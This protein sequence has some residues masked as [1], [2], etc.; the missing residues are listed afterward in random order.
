MGNHPVKAAYSGRN[1]IMPRAVWTGAEAIETSGETVGGVDVDNA[2]KTLPQNFNAGLMVGSE[3]RE[4][5][6]RESKKAFMPLAGASGKLRALEPEKAQ[7]SSE[8][9]MGKSVDELLHSAREQSLMNRLTQII[10]KEIRESKAFGIAKPENEQKGEANEKTFVL[11]KD[12]IPEGAE[13]KSAGKQDAK[14]Q[15]LDSNIKKFEGM[16]INAQKNSAQEIS[17][18]GTSNSP[19]TIENLDEISGKIEFGMDRV[20]ENGESVIRVRLRPEELGRIEIRLVQENGIVKGS[21]LV[22]N[23]GVKEQMCNL[24]LEDK[25][26][27]ALD[28]IKP[29]EIEVGVFNQQTGT[30]KDFGQG[31]SDFQKESRSG[32][33]SDDSKETRDNVWQGS[34][35]G[36]DIQKGLDLFA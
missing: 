19:R 8:G 10:P 12:I 24:L 25:F 22:E 3:S 17:G 6:L 29:K 21:I 5:D 14:R 9:A 20:R 35:E 28:G 13:A 34:E 18:T 32:G 16:P 26:L 2:K 11:V 23:E 4:M 15:L 30:F 27:Q 33:F 36:Q 1:T 31:A 7:I